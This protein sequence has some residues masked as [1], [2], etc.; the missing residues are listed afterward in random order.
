MIEA[1]IYKNQLIIAIGHLTQRRQQILQKYF[2]E[3]YTVTEIA[4]SLSISKSR[5]SQ[6]LSKSVKKLGQSF[7]N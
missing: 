7:L 1:S 3:G 5:V 2:F 4:E 6:V